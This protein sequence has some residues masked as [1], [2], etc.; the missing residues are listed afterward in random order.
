MHSEKEQ[1]FSAPGFTLTE[2]M[3]AIAIFGLIAVMFFGMLRTSGIIN[4]RVNVQSELH[5]EG[6]IALEKITRSIRE[7]MVGFPSGLTNVSYASGNFTNALIIL[8][9]TDH[10][11]IGDSLK[12]WGVAPL[13][14]DTNG[15][16]DK[17][18]MDHVDTA[19]WTLVQVTAPSTN[20]A[21]ATWSVEVLCKNISVPWSAADGLHTNTYNPFEYAGAVGGV[22]DLDT[23]GDGYVSQ[24]EIG[25]FVNG[26][27]VIDNVAEV[28][29][30]VT[31]G[32]GLRL[33]KMS[34]FGKVESV[35]I[36]RGTVAPRNWK[37]L[38]YKD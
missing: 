22:S 31:I 11:G 26:N 35:I 24:K 27:G 14:E 37:S 28:E 30:I 12:G 8:A 3:C 5:G 9:D 21:A 6:K 13:D 29:R 19:L 1:R 10:N 2:I 4:K 15:I 17:V 38:H 16:Q 33:L 20:L 36:Y 18:A 34:A 25:D 23:D 32:L 7:E